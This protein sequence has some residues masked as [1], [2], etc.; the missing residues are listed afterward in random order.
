VAAKDDVMRS[1]ISGK[2]I[3]DEVFDISWQG[4][5]DKKFIQRELWT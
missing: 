4:R 3:Y 5:W 1:A 2:K